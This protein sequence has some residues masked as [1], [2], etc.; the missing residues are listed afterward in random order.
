MA[1]WNSREELLPKQ[2]HRWIVYLGL[3]NNNATS[4]SDNSLPYYFAKTVERPSF[5]LKTQ[6]V[7]YL[8]SHTFN[9]PTR[10]IWNPIKI[11]FYDVVMPNF[12]QELMFSP[13]INSNNDGATD[14]SGFKYVDQST[15]VFFYKFLQQAGYYNPE[16]LSREDQLLRFRS[17]TFKKNMVKSLVGRSDSDEDYINSR[18][19]IGSGEKQRYNSNN[20]IDTELFN[21]LEIRELNEKG[22]P[23]ETC[24]L[25]NPLISDVTF[26]KLDYSQDNVVTITCTV[27]YDYAEL[28][29]VRRNVAVNMQ[30]LST[31]FTAAMQAANSQP[32]QSDLLQ[33]R[34]QESIPQMFKQIEQNNQQKPAVTPVLRNTIPK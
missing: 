21:S 29:P 9:F 33:P 26:D 10:V 1:F 30:E 17:Y 20:I 16:E 22:E 27:A 2:Q 7:K 28:S 5:S 12:R 8:Y 15:Q 3:H 13:A 31:S 6:Q 24:K 18:L 11:I 4:N 25:Y 34:G 32:L 19:P 23:I 14:T